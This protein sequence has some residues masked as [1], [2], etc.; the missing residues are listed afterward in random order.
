MARELEVFLEGKEERSPKMVDGNRDNGT[1]NV[2]VGGVG[3]ALNT[4]N[5]EEHE[6]GKIGVK[7]HINDN[8]SDVTNHSEFASGARDAPDKPVIES[9][10][11]SPLTF[12]SPSLPQ[13]SATAQLSHRYLDTA[14]IQPV[15]YVIKPYSDIWK[16]STRIYTRRD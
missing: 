5:I 16:P 2:V 6:E 9:S 10:G 12:P 4:L 15:E 11:W 14:G 13:K 3:V 8:D 1:N 7:D